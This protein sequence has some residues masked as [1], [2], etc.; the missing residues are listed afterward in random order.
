[1][2]GAPGAELAV[3]PTDGDRVPVSLRDV[4]AAAEARLRRVFATRREQTA[5]IAPEVADLTDLITTFTLS[6]G[7]RVRPVFAWSGYRC[8]GGVL[9]TSDAVAALDLCAALELIQACALIHDDVIDLSDTRRGNPTVHRS[10]TA[11]HRH[12]SWSG[13][14]DHFGMSTAILLGDLALSWADDLVIAA[15][16]GPGIRTRIGP[17][18][19]AMRTEVLAGQ[20]LDVVGEAGDDESVDAAFRV[21]RFKTAGYTVA[22]PLQLGAVAAD[23][24]DDLVATLGQVGD[25]LGIAFQLRDDLLG[26]FGDPERTG[27]P[28]GDDLVAG[29]RTALLALALQNADADAPRVAAELRGLVGRP[30]DERELDRAR[31]I[32]HDVGAVRAVE[33]H[34]T[35][36]VDESVDILSSAP[37]E[38][39]AREELVA[40]A[41]AIA[42]R[43]M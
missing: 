36:L 3:T 18:W 7:K 32:L 15:D 2:T 16:L 38:A 24:P 42:G 34:I 6:G 9:D 14:A 17:V 22:R 41:T 1:V 23:A 37:V 20:I 33:D 11:T 31:A 39:T 21:M 19:S 13:D 27:K 40:Y 4:P 43:R 28:S 8:A 35:R 26:V 5:A 10:V 29:K 30:L 12:R 25:G